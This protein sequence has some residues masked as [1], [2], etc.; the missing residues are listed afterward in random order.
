M[1]D[2]FKD[3]DILAPPKRIAKLG[4]YDIDVS[5][6]SARVSLKFIQF[7]QKHSFNVENLQA[8][9]SMDVSALEDM[10]DII[11]IICQR[12]A[13]E[14]TKD[15]L[16]DNVDMATLIEFIT[17]IFQPLN[18]LIEKTEKENAQAKGEKGKNLP[19]PT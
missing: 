17:F 8:S 18:R 13:P 7:S 14:I 10:I 12:T 4:G 9:Q 2:E 11:A 16:L 3:F 1:E 6:V 15:Y 19:S 5:I